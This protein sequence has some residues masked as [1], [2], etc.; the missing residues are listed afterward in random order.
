M[1]QTYEF[2]EISDLV[3]NNYTVRALFDVSKKTIFYISI[4]ILAKPKGNCEISCV[5]CYCFALFFS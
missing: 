2:D 5:V 3:K 4:E 1:A